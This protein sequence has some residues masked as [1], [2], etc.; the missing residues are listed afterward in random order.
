MPP[1]RLAFERVLH[2]F[3]LLHV[4]RY[5]GVEY[6]PDD[7][8]RGVFRATREKLLIK[9]IRPRTRG[10]SAF[11]RRCMTK[12][13]HNVLV[14]RDTDAAVRHAQV[15]YLAMWCRHARVCDLTFCLSLFLSL[16]SDPTTLMVMT[17]DPL[18]LQCGLYAVWSL[19]VYIM[20]GSTSPA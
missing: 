14:K 20:R 3:L 2:P 16:R 8:A 17:H 1:I 15:G 10:A 4:N 19:V 11:V 12:V 13:L 9:G 5:A 7:V 18:I 6:G